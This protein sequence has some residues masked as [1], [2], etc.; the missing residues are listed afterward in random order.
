[1]FTFGS[2]T[3]LSLRGSNQSHGMP[4]ARLTFELEALRARTCS[5]IFSRKEEVFSLR[6]LFL[7]WKNSLRFLKI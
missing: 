3:S 1:M 5:A 2:P 6:N 4:C 7:N